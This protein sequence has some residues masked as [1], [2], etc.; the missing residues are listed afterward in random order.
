MRQN[1]IALEELDGKGVKSMSEILSDA[2]LWLCLNMQIGWGKPCEKKWL[3]A[4][5]EPSLP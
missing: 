4:R 2:R 5:V 3:V 1:K